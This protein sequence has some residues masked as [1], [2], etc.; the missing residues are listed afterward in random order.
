MKRAAVFLAILVFAGIPAAAAKNTK[1][2]QK[3]IQSGTKKLEQIQKSLQE[4]R[5]EKEQCLQEEKCIKLEL[6]RI[7]Q[8]LTRLSAEKEKLRREI[9]KAERNVAAADKELQAAGWEKSQWSNVLSREADLWYRAH[10][11]YYQFYSDPV[12]ERLRRDALLQK[13]HYVTNASIKEENS[14][15]ALKK[16]QA[17]TDRLVSLR[18]QQEATSR[19][20]TTIGRR[21][22]AEEEI[23]KLSESAKALENLINKLVR[24]KKKV[25]DEL[26]ERSAKKQFQDK[27]KHLPWPVSGDVTVAFGKSKHPELDTYVI[28]NGIKI[29][30]APGTPVAAVD[31]GEVIFCGEFRAYGLMII[32]DHGG[33]FCSIYGLLGE[34]SVEE[35]QK[36]KTG[37]ALGRLSAQG[38]S[39]LYF[40]VRSAGKVEDPLLWLR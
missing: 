15:R 18:K 32:V 24:A 25:E 13:K 27:K 1:Q 35:G 5:S 31:K 6:K 8:E 40:E 10:Y 33:G 16:W 19:T 36:I 17:A 7:D 37:Q 20:K 21:I 2:Y 34:V 28:S 38:E 3:E 30:S 29:H 22:V 26:A 4:K 39:L 11:S 14:L 9:G 12:T 23:E